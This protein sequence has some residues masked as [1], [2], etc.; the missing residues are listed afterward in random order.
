MT[1]QSDAG[2]NLKCALETREQNEAAVAEGMNKARAECSRT[3]PPVTG[4]ALL[5][6]IDQ[7]AQQRSLDSQ[8][9]ALLCDWPD[10]A[11]IG[12]AWFDLK[13]PGMS[14]SSPCW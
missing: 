5:D 11:S 12:Q 1:N 9:A 3:A 13:Y 7:L 6:R 2:A 8:D 10:A 4:Q 14:A